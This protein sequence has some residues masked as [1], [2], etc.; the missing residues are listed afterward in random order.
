MIEQLK[1]LAMEKLQETMGANSLNAEATNG[2]AEEGASS[3]ID[4]LMEKVG[5]GDLSSLTS[6]FSNDGNAT[7]DSGIV[8]NLQGKLAEILQNKGM[9]AGEAAT[10]ASSIA[11]GLVDS[12]KDK[13]VSSEEGDSMFSLE[14]LASLAGGDAAGGLLGA[15]KSLF[16]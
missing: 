8:Q 15:A 11:P 2:A 4:G 9:D 5:S 12:L 7:A 1:K 3:L 14:N 6:L 16:N 10:E 13:F